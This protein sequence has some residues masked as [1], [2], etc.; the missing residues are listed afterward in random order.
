MIEDLEGVLFPDCL[1]DS[2]E[3]LSGCGVFTFVDFSAILTA[4]ALS[5]SA[6]VMAWGGR[7]GGAV[8]VP[9]RLWHSLSGALSGCRPSPTASVHRG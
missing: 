9:A 5:S 3:Q 8:A 4:P 7:I 2:F 6:N 1:G